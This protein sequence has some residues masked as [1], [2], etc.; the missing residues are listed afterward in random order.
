MNYN[1][2]CLKTPYRCCQSLVFKQKWMWKQSYQFILSNSLLQTLRLWETHSSWYYWTFCLPLVVT[3]CQL[4]TLAKENK[5]LTAKG[6][7]GRQ[8]HSIYPMDVFWP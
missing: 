7:N 1:D 3:T 6:V 2:I 8:V 5:S 4:R